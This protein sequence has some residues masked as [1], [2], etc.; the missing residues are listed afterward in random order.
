[1]DAIITTCGTRVRLLRPF[2]ASRLE[3]VSPPL[4]RIQASA[5][6]KIDALFARC[7][8]K[9]DQKRLV[10]VLDKLA[11]SRSSSEHVR[12][13]PQKAVQDPFPNKVLLRHVEPTASF[14]TEALRQAW[15]R[16]RGKYL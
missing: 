11:E 3:D 4:K 14:Q 6:Q 10:R 15:T 2:L 1:V 7:P 13:F 9:S 16:V 5:E 8:E 12:D